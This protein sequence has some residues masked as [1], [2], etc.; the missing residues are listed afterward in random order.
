MIVR[1]PIEEVSISSEN[2]C[3][4]LFCGLGNCDKISHKKN[5]KANM[6]M[7]IIWY[8]QDKPNVSKWTLSDLTQWSSR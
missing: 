1:L 3:S 7:I 6:R 5:Y 8:F 2:R 4:I